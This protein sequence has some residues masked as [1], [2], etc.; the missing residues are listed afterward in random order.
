MNLL[1]M[2]IRRPVAVAMLF[3][4]IAALGIYFI[5]KLPLE[6]LPTTNL[7][8]LSITASWPYTSA[9]TVEAF[10][11]SPIEGI[12]QTV[13]GVK[14]VNSTSSEGTASISAQFAKGTDMDFAVL[15]LNEKLSVLKSEL[16]EGTTVPE[17]KNYAATSSVRGF[18]RPPPLRYTL[19]GD[20]TLPWIRQY[21]IDKLRVP[22]VAIDG[23]GDVRIAGGQERVLKI[24]IDP[25]KAEMYGIQEGAVSSAIHSLE[26]KRNIASLLRSGTRYDVYIENDAESI[27]E[28]GD[29]VVRKIGGT[30]ILLKDIATLIDG[31]QEPRDY[32]R[33]NSNSLV[34]ITI[35]HE[36]GANIIEFV[37]AVDAKIQELE[38]EFPSGLQ[39]IQEN[40]PSTT[41]QNDLDS[42][43]ARGIFCIL[44]IFAVL[45]IFIRNVKVPLM[46][47]TT[48]AFSVLITIIFFYAVGIGFNVMT[49]AGIALAFGMLVDSSIVV[50]DNIFRYR[51]RGE[52]P[53][54]SAEKG[55]REVFLPIVASVLTTSI[56]FIPFLYLQGDNR[57]IYIPMA[58]A[59]A[60][61]LI[62]SILVAFTF[63]PT[64]SVKVFPKSAE[65][66]QE[67]VSKNKILQYIIG[68]Y[69][70]FIELVI[71]HKY[72]TLRIVVA[73]FA[74]SWFVFTLTV[75]SYYYGT[76][77]GLPAYIRVYVSLPQGSILDRAND[78]ALSFE[79]MVLY[80]EH[81]EGV[82][83]VT[84]DVTPTRM[85]MNI[86]FADKALETAIPYLL[87]DE[88]TSYAS[89]FAGVSI[90]VTGV[91]DYFST[92]GLGGSLGG[93]VS[94]R[95][96]IRG[97]NYNKLAEIAE[98]LGRQFGQISRVKNVDTNYYGS[99]DRFD[100]VIRIKRDALST[101]NLDV[102]TVI[103][104]INRYARRS[105]IGTSSI[106][107]QDKLVRY[108]V[109]IK[110]FEELQ[111]E[112]LKNVIISTP[113]GEQV[114]LSQI[115]EFDEQKVM[116]SIQRFEQQYERVVGL[117][118]R[119]PT[120]IGRD[121]VNAI[122]EGKTYPNGYTV[123]EGRFSSYMPISF[124]EKLNK[125][126]AILFAIILVYMVTSSLYE[127]LLHPFVIILT[128]PMALIGV[129]LIFFIMGK[130]FT[131]AAYVGVI[132]LAG[133]V[134]N[135]SIILVDHINLLRKRGMDLYS[136]VIQGCK[137]RVRPILMTSATTIMGMFP[138]VANLWFFQQSRAYD[139]QI[140]YSL[141]LA[142]IGGLITA[143]P[144]TLSVIPVLY[145]LFEE[146]RIG[147]R[148]HLSE[149]Q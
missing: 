100:T 48:V 10:L 69:E 115:V 90:S 46:I 116:G 61:S 4:V 79:D 37:G 120:Q 89:T 31:H 68:L 65:T 135:N 63:I 54:D 14:E 21:A 20:Y 104:I 118:Y 102:A 134:V 39:I 12:V 38:K 140:W 128:V 133:I 78:I 143:T 73:V 138:L 81:R 58:L 25:V 51:E 28:I 94:F 105:S 13:K 97:Y 87:K 142:T 146:W 137:D 117:E 84:T 3:L 53:F 122:I 145:I 106:N 1:G 74:V 132:L 88:L 129:F 98:D 59:V 144:L 113:G 43:K 123:K 92:G 29:L 9:E 82:R 77:S 72:W 131:D 86:Q 110:D 19:T 148:V 50:I 47:M 36:D 141:A 111:L 41:V 22:L 125:W 11:T 101:Y 103:S 62:S 17:V 114:R 91:G 32:H 108:A 2:S 66:I 80:G 30:F 26:E 99:R 45:Y 109:K 95:V 119:G 76:G 42:I 130:T 5:Q 27:D 15:E 44:V 83:K 121:A 64:Y 18:T 67:S 60:F 56:V 55:A 49:I 149:I 107:V 8:R 33:I 85:S 124:R 126:L 40:D 16:P 139:Q 24:E 7:P 23:V 71:H 34:G 147:M 127:S 6:T 35:E 52:S 75:P 57:V 136:A 112:D 93:P 70:R 96:Y